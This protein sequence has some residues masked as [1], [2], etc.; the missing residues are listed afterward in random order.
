MLA[1]LGW[2]LILAFCTACVDETQTPV[3]PDWRGIDP[4]FR[5][6]Y[7]FLG[8]EEMLGQAVSPPYQEGSATSQFVEKGK[9]IYNPD[10]PALSLFRLAPLGLEMRVEEPPVPQPNQPGIP[11]MNG[12]TIHPDFMPL[13]EKLGPTTVGRPITELRYNPLRKRYEQFF[14]NL[15][16]YRLEG[17]D[18]IGLL[19][20]GLWAC[21]HSCREGGGSPDAEMDIQYYIDPLFHDYVNGKGADFTGFAL[22]DLY[23]A[24]DGKKEQILENVVL[25]EQS[26][27]QVDLRPLAEKLSI[28]PETPRESS[29][30]PNMYFYVVDGNKGYEIPKYFLDYITQHGG[31]ETFGA[32]I[33]HYA[34]FIGAT[35]HQ[36]FAR[37]CLVYNP[38]AVEGAKVRPE[39]LG[40]AFKV[41]YY[42]G[43]NLT[44]VQS[45]TTPAP[46]QVPGTEVLL[47]VWYQYPAIASNQA[48][49][50]GAVLTQNDQPVSNVILSLDVTHPDGSH[51]S[52]LFPPTDNK[53]HTSLRI[54][55]IDGSNSTLVP[56]KVCIEMQGGI[57][58]CVG[59]SYVIWNNP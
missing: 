51:E 9:L 6:Y 30:D 46:P 21:D 59:D 55:P 53:G 38:S 5:E 15:G 56:F 14:E 11:Y 22:T 25:Y 44:P 39:P 54:A 33:S 48:Q 31:F 7:E 2:V 12:H 43:M 18:Q 47:Q 20:Y 16:F 49:E 36:C 29:N 3:P 37:L 1:A 23:L 41:L 17:T 8:G 24:S 42:D 32:P 10:A 26:Q 4:I 35:Y 57:K 40:Y 34:P 52:H 28:Y 13:Y 50:I 58:F 27:G 45:T 19:A